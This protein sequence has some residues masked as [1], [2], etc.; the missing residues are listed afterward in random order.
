MAVDTIISDQMSWNFAQYLVN[1]ISSNAVNKFL[2]HLS[3]RAISTGG[4]QID[5]PSRSEE[6]M[7]PVKRVLKKLK[8]ES[9]KGSKGIEIKRLQK[10]K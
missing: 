3:S 10:L 9:D 6:K 5:P 4:G 1:S 2:A 7:N 8:S